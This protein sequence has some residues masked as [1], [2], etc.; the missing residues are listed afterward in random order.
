MTDEDQRRYERDGS[1]H[2]RWRER[3]HVEQQATAA[4]DLSS[5]IPVGR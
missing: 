1:L 5:G 3:A 2:A 4:R